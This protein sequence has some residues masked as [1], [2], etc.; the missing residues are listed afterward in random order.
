M[1]LRPDLIATYEDKYMLC[2]FVRWGVMKE[3]YPFMS[4]H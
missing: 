3:Q 1:E 2:V 4:S